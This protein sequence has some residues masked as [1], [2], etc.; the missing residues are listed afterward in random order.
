MGLL[1]DLN[2]TV[3]PPNRVQRTLQHVAAGE[4]I[5]RLLQRSLHPLDKVVHGAT[6]GRTTAAGLLAGIPVIM[7]RTVGARTGRVRTNPLIG[8]PM[9]EDLAVIGSNFGTAATPGWVYNLES[10]P[11]AV[12]SYRDRRATV[13]ARP[14]DDVETDQAFDAAAAVYAAFPAYRNRADHRKTRV[15]ALE[16]AM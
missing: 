3:T 16:P 8:I 10:N 14:A 2:Y 15:F 7:L 12:V 11:A 9:G 4:R 1:D 6:L 13:T 5:G